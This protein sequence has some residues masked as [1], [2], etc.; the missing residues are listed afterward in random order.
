MLCLDLK[1]LAYFDGNASNK[2]SDAA[3]SPHL[4]PGSTP[5]ANRRPVENRLPRLK[6]IRSD[7]KCN[8][9][10]TLSRMSLPTELSACLLVSIVIANGRYN[11]LTA[12][13]RAQNVRHVKR[14]CPVGLCERYEEAGACKPEK[15]IHRSCGENI[16]VPGDELEMKLTSCCKTRELRALRTPLLQCSNAWNVSLCGQV[17]PPQGSQVNILPIRQAACLS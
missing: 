17:F 7:R 13:R 14:K 12:V 16:S 3:R 4:L 6:S 11:F 15:D 10:M 2:Q 9:G 8:V 1:G 5:T